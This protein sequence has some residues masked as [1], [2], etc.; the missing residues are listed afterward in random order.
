MAVSSTAFSSP[1]SGY[2]ILKLFNKFRNGTLVLRPVLSGRKRSY[3]RLPWWKTNKKIYLIHSM[4]EKSTI[5]P[6]Y[7][8]VDDNDIMYVVDGLQR[9]SCM[10]EFLSNE[11]RLSSKSMLEKDLEV[12][13]P[14]L[15]GNRWK[16]LSDEAK[17]SLS[18]YQV[19]LEQIHH[20]IGMTDQAFEQRIKK[21]FHRINVTAGGM[22]EM[23]IF[24]NTFSGDL[25]DL[26]YELQEALGFKGLDP[27]KSYKLDVKSATEDYYLAATKVVSA[28]D[29]LRLKDLDLILQL[30]FMIHNMGKRDAAGNM[31]IV[32]KDD[33]I[34]AYCQNNTSMLASQTKAMKAS[35]VTD[36]AVIKKL[37]ACEDFSLKESIF[38]K[39]HDFYSL[40]ST[41]ESLRLDGTLSGELNF[42]V[43]ATNLA[44]FSGA[45]E[46]FKMSLA[47]ADD[48]AWEALGLPVLVKKEAR[49]YYLTRVRDWNTGASRK[50][51]LGILRGIF[52]RKNTIQM[53]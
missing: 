45:V 50:T 53:S 7:V 30:L 35:F 52:A 13:S 15:D 25:T 44:I 47:T 36:L 32:N 26:L 39:E 18:S 1:V 5:P 17:E 43:I 24:N 14:D 16:D 29:L 28:N 12:L 41:V 46:T 31:T 23:E 9:L 8:Y 6:I 11:L 3:Q 42:S 49:E 37:E 10:F 51:R 22:T 19:R 2:S 38:R 48:T 34:Q 20:P 33:G 21:F 4:F 40:F 27:A